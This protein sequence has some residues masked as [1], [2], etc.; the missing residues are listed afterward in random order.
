M[1]GIEGEL[2]ALLGDEGEGMDG[3]LLELWEAD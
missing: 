1:D 3:A 2:D